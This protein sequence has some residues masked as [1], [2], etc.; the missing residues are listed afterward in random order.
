MVDAGFRDKEQIQ[1]LRTDAVFP[2]GL[3]VFK[4]KAF[5]ETA[6]RVEDLPTRGE[7]GA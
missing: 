7:H 1:A 5:V 4:R 2:F 3:L 6:R